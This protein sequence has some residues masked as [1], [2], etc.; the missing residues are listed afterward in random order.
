MTIE[1]DKMAKNFARFLAAD[2]Y[3]ATMKLAWQGTH[4]VKVAWHRTLASSFDPNI[5]ASQGSKECSGLPDYFDWSIAILATLMTN[6][7][8]YIDGWPRE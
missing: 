4:I 7:P 5:W 8:I 6:F 2:F 3:G 1:F